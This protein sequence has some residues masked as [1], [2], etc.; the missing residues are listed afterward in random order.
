MVGMEIQECADYS[1]ADL[2]VMKE[3][4]LTSKL[5]PHPHQ[6]PKL[7]I[8]RPCLYFLKRELN[9]FGLLG[10]SLCSLR[11]SDQRLQFSIWGGVKARRHWLLS[12]PSLLCA[13]CCLKKTNM[14]G[15]AHKISYLHC[16]QMLHG[17]LCELACHCL[18]RETASQNFLLLG[19][20][21]H[22][23]GGFHLG[24]N[25]QFCVTSLTMT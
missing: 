9:K 10:L 5:G 18:A 15:C 21:P 25:Q 20:T 7:I 12:V 17:G 16:S 14:Q 24:P 4:V 3:T 23:H 2:R 1:W 8:C 11:K 13:I 6:H 19:H 22:I